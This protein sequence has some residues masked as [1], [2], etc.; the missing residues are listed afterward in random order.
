M[1]WQTSQPRKQRVG[2][3]RRTD[4]ANGVDY[5]T[6]QTAKLAHHLRSARKMALT[7]KVQPQWTTL[8]NT[9]VTDRE[10]YSAAKPQE[11]STEAPRWTNQ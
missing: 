7:K 6:N 11:V 9:N 4:E 5:D 3:K 2:D 1:K 10:L 8:W